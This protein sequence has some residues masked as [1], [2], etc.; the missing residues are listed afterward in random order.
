MSDPKTLLQLAGADL[1]PPKLAD[2][3]LV[4]IDMQNEYLDGPLALPDARAA[5]TRA[6]SLVSMKRRPVVRFF[7]LPTRAGQEACLIATQ[8]VAGS[9]MISRRSAMRR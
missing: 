5:I 9:L 2:A 1:Q 3:C 7:M 4:V 8:S 6:Q